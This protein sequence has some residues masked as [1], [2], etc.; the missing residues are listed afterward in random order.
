NLNMMSSTT[1]DKIYKDNPMLEVKSAGIN[2]EAFVRIDDQLVDW[3]DIIFVMEK[4]QKKFIEKKF[5]T[6]CLD[7]K[8]INL[9]ISDDYYYM[10]PDLV[11]I[12]KSTVETH[13]NHYC[14]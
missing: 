4:N 1:A 13:I 2:I 14:E 9:N 12:L 7:K 3:A 8:I 11:T 5:K 6:T 10:D